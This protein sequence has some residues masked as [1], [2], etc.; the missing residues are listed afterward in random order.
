MGLVQDW[1]SFETIPKRITGQVHFIVL[2]LPLCTSDYENVIPK[3]QNLRKN[4]HWAAPARP[5]N[6]SRA[7]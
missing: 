3:T 6:S 4:A 1:V 2:K 5:A 7:R